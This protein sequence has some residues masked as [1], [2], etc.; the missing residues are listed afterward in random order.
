MQERSQRYRVMLAGGGTG[1]HVFPAIAI[2]NAVCQK[3]PESEVL[4]VGAL[5]RME[6][7]RVPEAGYRI[8]GLPIVGMPRKR[9]V[10]AMVRFLWSWYRS[11]RKARRLIRDFS[12][13]V[14]VGVGGYASVP[15]MQMAQRAGVGTVIQE[16]N[17]YAGKANKL[18][19]HKAR[20]VCVAYEGMER[21]FP[22]DKIRLTGNPVRQLVL[23]PHPECEEA[24]QALGLPLEAK[25]VLVVGG[26]LGAT[27]LNESVVG[28]L[29]MLRNRPDVSVVLQT[30][31][32]GYHAVQAATAG[33]DGGNLIVR[34]FISRMDYAYAAADV[35]VSRAGAIAISEMC[36]VG[37]PVVLVPSPNVAED[38][39]TKN[40]EVL[41][42]HG[43]ALLLR[44]ALAR[45][46]LMPRVFEL[47][48][49]EPRCQRMGAAISKLARTNAAV[50]IAKYVLEVAEEGRSHGA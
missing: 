42:H 23:P 28:A 26:S 18:L 10:G 45:E 5:G 7:E 2:A 43:A 46:Q 8:V 49:D 17:G 32:H 40:A 48:S 29:D 9:Q 16:Q 27:T 15:V 50:E 47:L 30:G 19:A 33:Y 31:A 21:Y 13:D 25:V 4:F 34:D 1:G 22:A 38:H 44:D 24:R 37:K 11:N 39:Q 35:I 12:P 41:A 36:L 20:H 6:M 3:A 14:V